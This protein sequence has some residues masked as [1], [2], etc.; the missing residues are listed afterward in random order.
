[1]NRIID[2]YIGKQVLMAIGL[3]LLVLLALQVFI[4]LVN[5]LGD[6]GKGDYTFSTSIK[7][8]FFRLPYDLSALFPMACL[9]GTLVGLGSMAEHS[10]LT[11]IRMSGMSM[12][13]ITAVI[14]QVAFVLIL[15]IAMSSEFIFPKFMD[16]AAEEKMLALSQGQAFTQSYGLWI[17][18]DQDFVFVQTSIGTKTLH[19]VLQFHLDKA[20]HMKFARKIKT[21]KFE[22]HQWTAYDIQQTNFSSQRL[23]QTV[24]PEMLWDIP[25]SQ[26]IIRL[27][28]KTPDEMSLGQL[29][30]VRASR[31]QISQGSFS[32]NYAFWSRLS[33]PFSTLVM[34]LLAIPFI[35]GPLRNSSIGYKVIVGAV[36]GFGFYTVTHFFGSVCQMLQWSPLLAAVAPIVCAA[37]FGVVFMRYAR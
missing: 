19:N 28:N 11:I 21:I 16:Y 9:L 8:I 32:V 29:W 35:F 26:D 12:L 6:I 30:R 4:L 33:Q 10:E 2:R 25:L 15:L 20:H 3:V 37:I 13:Q 34:M 18:A 5:E 7:V 31:Q 36:V 14:C 1:M 23:T 17:R 22:N 27:H 24:L